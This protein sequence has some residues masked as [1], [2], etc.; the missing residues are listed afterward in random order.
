MS[1]SVDAVKIKQIEKQLLSEFLRICKKH[2]LRYFLVGGTCLGAVRHKG[3]IPWDDDIDVG[4][5]RRDY[6]IFLKVAPEE[7]PE[8]YFLQCAA[9]EPEHSCNHAKLRDSETTF[10]ETSVKDF[11]INHG[12]FMD[13]FPLD[14]Y[15]QRLFR[16]FM[17]K[18]YTFRMW[19]EYYF[20]GKTLSPR[21]KLLAKAVKLLC[22]DFRKAR[23]KREA[24]FKKDDFD[25]SAMATNFCGAWGDREIMHRSYFGEGTEG[26]FE[27]LKVNLPEKYDAYLK[28]LYGDYMKLPP[29][30]KRI[31]H[32]HTEIL[33]LEHSYKMYEK[34]D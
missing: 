12:V 2:D 34:K 17:N 25:T 13:V 7:L 16:D 24:L 4:M 20:P 23:D 21:D 30:E 9:T 5:P 14:G 27:G 1:N 8:R 33:D 26:E 32:H 19:R 29:E 18:I 3:F 15:K 22:G 11:H 6:E 31:S 28:N 10:W